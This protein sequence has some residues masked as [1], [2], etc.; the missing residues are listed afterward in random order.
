AERAAARLLREAG[1]PRAVGKARG[2]AGPLLVFVK[3][4][5]SAVGSGLGHHIDEASGTAPEFGGR[6]IGHHLE[7]FDRV[8]T[9][10]ER[11]ALAA[12]LFAEEGGVVVG[13]LDRN[14]VI[15]TLFPVGRNL[16][17]IRTLNDR[18]ARRERPAAEE[19]T[20][21]IREIMDRALIEIR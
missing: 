5:V 19:I 18:N 8:E 12:A 10:G 1:K 20:A 7:F 11:R 14:I 4:P 13:A 17:A 3:R 9:D 21:I 16:I 2:Q 6:A 15:N